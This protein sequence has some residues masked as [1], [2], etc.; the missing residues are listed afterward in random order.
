MKQRWGL[1]LDVAIDFANRQAY[2]K[3]YPLKKVNFISLH[4]RYIADVKY[5]GVP[6]YPVAKPAYA[7][8]PPPPAYGPAPIVA[9]G[10]IVAGPGPFGPGPH[11]PGPRPF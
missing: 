10:P 2:L 3:L 7:P 6:A 8:A 9:A 4:F 11:G 1:V 5:E